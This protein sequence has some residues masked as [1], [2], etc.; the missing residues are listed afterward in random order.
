M[1]KRPNPTVESV[2]LPFWTAL[3]FPLI[4]LVMFAAAAC[5]PIPDRSQ[6]Q[7]KSDAY[8]ISVWHDDQRQVTCWLSH[9]YVGNSIS[10]LPD[11]QIKR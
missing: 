11:S 5:G 4:V 2:G 6:P 3:I 8:N 10:C 1:P 9:V 7:T